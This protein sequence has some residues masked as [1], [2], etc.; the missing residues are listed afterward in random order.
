[1]F[2]SKESNTYLSQILDRQNDILKTLES[3]DRNIVKY[4]GGEYDLKEKELTQKILDVKLTKKQF[5]VLQ[6]T[7]DH[8]REKH[9]KKTNEVRTCSKIYENGNIEVYVH[10]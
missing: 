3:I 5:D 7:V 10:E 8:V 4:F 1:M 6:E 9:S 2:G